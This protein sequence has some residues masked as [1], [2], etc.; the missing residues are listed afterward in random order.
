M[1]RLPDDSAASSP[2][3]TTGIRS[4]LDGM[5]TDTGP[6][7][8]D[9]PASVD[10]P[11]FVPNDPLFANGD[12][13]HLNQMG[14]IDT[15][16]DD[17]Q[18]WGVTVGVYDGGVQRDHPDLNDNYDTGLHV[19]VG[20]ALHD[21]YP[22]TAADT[23]HGTAVAGV[24]ASE[25]DNGIGGLGVAPGATLGSVAI[26]GTTSNADINTAYPGF[27]EAAMQMGEFDITNHSWGRG[28]VFQSYTNDPST[29]AAFRVATH[30]GRDGL[31]TINLKA[32]GNDGASSQ[33]DVRNVDRTT[34]SVNAV[35][36]DGFISWYSN[37]GSNALITAPTSDTGLN[38]GITTTD[39]TGVD[40]YTTGDYTSTFGGTSSA[41]PAAAGVVALM[42]EADPEL[43]WRDVQEI[44]S[45]SSTHTG[46]DIGGGL[47]FYE[48]D[49]WYFNASGDWNN[50]GRHF[51]NDYGFGSVDAYNAVRM[52]EIWE[53][54]VPMSQTSANEDKL[55]DFSYSPAQAI[56]EGATINRLVGT[57]GST[58]GIV[59]YGLV[60]LDITHGD[61]SDLQ[62][63]ITSESGTVVEI[64][65]ASDN[66]LSNGGAVWTFG[67][68]SLR[69]E[70]LQDVGTLQINITDTD[71]GD[72]QT[73]TFNSYRV[74][75]YGQAN[76]SPGTDNIY[77]YT[78]EVFWA[79]GHEPGRATLTDTGGMDAINAAAMSGNLLVDLDLGDMQQNGVQFGTIAAGSVLERV[80]TGDGND[81]IL[82]NG[83]DNEFFGMRGDDSM[84]GR[85]GEDT[86]VGGEGADYHHG[87]AGS[88]MIDH[89]RSDR[90]IDIR[91]WNGTSS[92]GDAEG[93]TLL[94]IENV[95][96]GGGNDILHGNTS[97]NLIEGGD[98][99]DT[100]L[101][102][103]GNDDLFGG[104][105]L[106]GD[107]IL[108]G[109]N[110]DLIEGGG[111]GDVLRGEAGDDT[112]SYSTD[113]TGV[114]VR[115]WNN[116]AMDGDAQGDFISGFENLQ[117]G[118]GDDLL[119]GDGTS[120]EISGG[121]GDDYLFA[122][123]GADTIMGGDGDDS[124]FG[125]G[126]ADDM[127]GGLGRDLLSY[128]T[129]STGVNVKIWNSTASGGEAAGDTF[130]GFE[131]L[132]GSSGNDTL[133]GAGGAN[134]IFGLNGA[135]IIL[136]LGGGDTL[137]G[138]NG[139]DNLQ[140][141]NGNDLIEGGSGADTLRGDGDID[142]LSYSEDTAGVSV[143]LWNNTATGGDAAGDDIGGFE[144]LTGGSGNDTLQGSAGDNVLMGGAGN[145][146]LYGLNSADTL[147]GGTGNDDLFGAVDGVTDVFEFTIG[148]GMDEIK[149]FE[150]GIDL[151]QFTLSSLVFGDLGISD[152]GTHA[153]VDYGVGDSILVLNTLAGSLTDADFNF[154]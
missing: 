114:S 101:G 136:G 143:R 25:A 80:F 58:Q 119:H 29:L 152:D 6:A 4:V 32:T 13:W 123:A 120:N 51:S 133:H 85:D 100:I 18:G 118:W 102:L 38:R 12:Q 89:S 145:D 22:V 52:S 69:G 44:L 3:S 139:A 54:L 70:Q 57:G 86:F 74:E 95:L 153:T 106:E 116:T 30:I 103:A 35:A 125:A 151:I 127:N 113:T 9:A 122:L 64:L 135:D 91:L 112:L 97:D 63:N 41:T 14:D 88:D 154:I 21:P 87:G 20:G 76:P 146:R 134:E 108:G 48:S 149:D 28:P 109:D 107:T 77:H 36:E 42:L 121:A 2:A 126:G 7:P 90:N 39:F 81:T 33:G 43:G 46:T 27:L 115:L 23:P 84:R 98:G 40:G 68:N 19:W 71:G 138:N 82:G 61:M 8:L 55:W 50:G 124:V 130:T 16:W 94:N 93:D 37:A 15:I 26:F 111:G 117:G 129:G 17:Y 99:Q 148:D 104:T 60:T 96:G 140:G 75:F 66:T 67:F 47:E 45:L 137:W 128:S 83:A 110:D 31:G 147:N 24:I 72:G 53:E 10:T 131:N 141:G 1:S 34:I 5:V 105:G 142:T 144:N 62:L 73:G 49:P 59:E 150:N 79:N 92:G 132:A 65:D 11:D 56:G 78:D